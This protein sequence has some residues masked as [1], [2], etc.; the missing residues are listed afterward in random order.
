MSEYETA[1]PA[2]QELSIR[3]VIG[4]GLLHA[5][6]IGCGLWMMRRASSDR[7]R[8]MGENRRV[9]DRRHD[10]A[11]QRHEEAMTALRAAYREDRAAAC[12]R[13]AGHWLR[14]SRQC[15]CELKE[16]PRNERI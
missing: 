4:A 9:A 11:R 6:P 13:T 10:E 16:W 15:I 12:R 3:A 8:A 1:S 5:V 2:L 7:N 14:G